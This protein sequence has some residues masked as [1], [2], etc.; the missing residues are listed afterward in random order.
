MCISQN[1]VN[2]SEEERWLFS[3]VK[4]ALWYKTFSSLWFTVTCTKNVL[5]HFPKGYSSL[6]FFFFT[7]EGAQIKSRLTG[8]FSGRQ[9]FVQWGHSFLH[10]EDQ[11]LFPIM[12]TCNLPVFV[13]L[14]QVEFISQATLSYS[15]L[16]LLNR[17]KFR[18]LASSPLAVPPLSRLPY[19]RYFSKHAWG[20][21]WKVL[22]YIDFHTL[23]MIE[24]EFKRN[25]RFWCCSPR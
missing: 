17:S 6:F 25:T 16:E 1:T 21:S 22:L 18:L 20:K 8:I 7:R 14:T 11:K 2:S 9:A 12:L 23:L 10:S 5:L 19:N 4:E 13:M 24:K 3:K 15:K